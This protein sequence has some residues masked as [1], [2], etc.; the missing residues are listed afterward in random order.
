MDMQKLLQD[1][2]IQLAIVVALTFLAYF[3]IF[4]NEFVWDDKDF[5]Q[6]WPAIQSWSNVPQLLQGELP[7]RHGGVFRPV[8]S[9]IYVAAYS[10]LQQNVFGYHVLSLMVHL[11]ATVLVYLI[12]VKITKK[13]LLAFFTAL[14]FGLQPVHTE[15]VTYITTNFDLWG[16][17]FLLASLYWY[18]LHLETGKKYWYVASLLFSGLAVF[19]YEIALVLPLILLAYEVIL[20]RSSK[21]R[22]SELVSESPTRIFA[23]KRNPEISADP[24]TSSGRPGRFGM[25]GR[26]F[27]SFLDN[28]GKIPWARIFKTLFPYFLLS[29]S[30][31]VIKIFVA[32]VTARPAP[33]LGGNITSHILTIVK[34]LAKY[35]TTTVLPM[36]LT[37][38]PQV[39]VATSFSDG[40]LVLSAAV[41]TVVVVGAVV[42][43]RKKN[44]IV[45]WAVAIFFI[46]LLP[47]MQMVPSKIV[48]AERYLYLAS[49][50]FCL[51][52][53]WIL[54]A[55]VSSQQRVKVYFGYLFLAVIVSGYIFTTVTRNQDW[56]SEAVL[57]AKTVAQAPQDARAQHNFGAVLS[58]RGDYRQ[59]I[60]VFQKAVTLDPGYVEAYNSL[61]MVFEASEQ[62]DQ[63]IVAYRKALMLEP[64]YLDAIRNLGDVYE[65][66]EEYGLAIEQYQAYLGLAPSDPAVHSNL[67]LVYLSTKRFDDAARSFGKALEL[68]PGLAPAK[69]GLALTFA[70]QGKY[71]EAKKLLQEIL[72]ADPNNAVAKEKLMLVEQLML[73]NKAE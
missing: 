34:I 49:F 56:R 16:I 19:T 71:A 24:E 17:V 31:F 7:G 68:N 60:M 44:A 1:K 54:Y 61:G 73:E 10:M 67:G 37:T 29:A 14:L 8:R 30:Y 47:V 15:A 3:N 4:R 64:R 43:L 63:A 25:T 50:G 53:G 57:W 21:N 39:G 42:S 22:H 58:Q 6:Q 28:L 36:N 11:L 62:H 26:Y 70:S 9:I 38:Y 41:V 33:L 20:R 59:A 55:M 32:H 52:L 72:A 5:I 35:V 66:K 40:S 12:T 69:L 45:L 18:L 46:S 2:R 27:E 23:Q 48:M 65:S 13:S 51:I